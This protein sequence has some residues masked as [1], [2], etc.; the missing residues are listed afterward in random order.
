M[1]V[2]PIEHH[3]ADLPLQ[4]R[5]VLYPESE[6]LSRTMAGAVGAFVRSGDPSVPA[7]AWPAFDEAQRLT[8]VFDKTCRVE[9]DP[10]R[11][12]REASV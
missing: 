4:L 12:V 7:L 3:T 11:A 10:W 8:M 2:G 9:S 1:P 6:A 5:V